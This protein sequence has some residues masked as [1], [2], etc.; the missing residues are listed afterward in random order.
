[1][2]VKLQQD[3]DYAL[4]NH[5][6]LSRN[7]EGFL[8]NRPLTTQLPFSV[9]NLAITEEELYCPLGHSLQS[10]PFGNHTYE[11]KSLPGY[12]K[13]PS[14]LFCD[15]WVT[16]LT[17]RSKWYRFRHWT[18]LYLAISHVSN[19]E[20]CYL[21]WFTGTY[22]K[23]KISEIGSVHFWVDLAALCLNFLPSIYSVMKGRI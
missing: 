8:L 10:I 19:M 20:D 4:I 13:D 14:P 9:F 18:Y 2:W 3:D 23:N 15:R 7:K 5:H 17:S 22:D 16:T 1:M 21:Y 12:I 6:S 11:K